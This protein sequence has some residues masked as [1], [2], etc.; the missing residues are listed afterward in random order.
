MPVTPMPP[1]LACFPLLHLALPEMTSCL[2]VDYLPST[3]MAVPDGEARLV[4]S[5]LGPTLCLPLD[6]RSINILKL[7]FGRDLFLDHEL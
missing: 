7:E 3:E 6:G 5:P 2:L 4:S 1:T